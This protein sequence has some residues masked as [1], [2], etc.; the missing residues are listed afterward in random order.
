MIALACA[1]LAVVALA[2]FGQ[3]RAREADGGVDASPVPVL[4]V[5]LIRPQE[6]VLPVRVSATGHVVAWQEASVG[7]EADGLRLTEVRVNVGDTVTRGQVLA[8]FKADTIEAE[9]AE[10]RAAVAQAAAEAGEAETNHRRAGRL[11]ATGAIA[12]QQVGQYA[13]GAATAR[14]RLDAARA[15]E[16]RVGLR[17]AQ[18]RVLAPS[19]GVITARPATVGAVVTAG[20]ELFRLIRDGRLEW[21]A[22]VSAADLDALAPGQA[23]TI[24]L[25]GHAPIHGT[26]RRLGP[27]IDVAT[28]T[29][30][31]YADLPRGSAV[32]AGAFV[33][34]HIAVGDRWALTL[35]RSA[36]LLRD[37]FH[38][39]M[40]VSVASRVVVQK[41]DVGRSVDDR[42]EIT[43][44]LA[45][46]EPVIAAGLGFLSEGDT[47][48]VVGELGPGA[49]AVP[50]SSTADADVTESNAPPPERSAPPRSSP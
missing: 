34:G 22:A 44:G 26:L 10:V 28:H 25:P 29:G 4:S 42:I 15:V 36:V 27:V 24:S 50:V 5:T 40:R 20:Q 35:P 23:A 21:R 16:R 18:T 14:A 32:R 9:L 3:G 38:T 7:A 41:V 12:A 39:V 30:L 13:A 2:L 1:G 47:V 6:S 31:A 33:S 37:G 48:R 17:L 43:A 11:G 49:A 46:S 19:D 45:A 8:L